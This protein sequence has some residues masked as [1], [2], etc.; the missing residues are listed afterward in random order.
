MTASEVERA[1][2]STLAMGLVVLLS[3]AAVVVFAGRGKYRHPT[4]VL[5]GLAALQLVAT[6]F[7]DAHNG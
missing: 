4:W 7:F 1:Q 2:A 3:V 6:V 5:M